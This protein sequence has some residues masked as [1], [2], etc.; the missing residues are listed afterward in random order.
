MRRKDLIGLK[1]A[2]W[3]TGMEA[4]AAARYLREVAPKQTFTYIDEKENAALPDQDQHPTDKLVTSEKD[5][6]QA[7]ET[8]DVVIKS[9]GVSLYHPLLQTARDRKV[10]IT[11]LLN[12]WSAENE[13]E[14][15]IAIT[16]TKGKSTTSS[17]LTHVLEQ[18]GKHV[19]LLG[20]F[21]VPVTECCTQDFD[22]VVV[23]FS[24]YQTATFDGRCG[25]GLLTALYPEHLDWHQ[26]LQTY[27]RDKSRLLQQ[28]DHALIGRQADDVMKAHALPCP[29]PAPDII[30]DEA[31]FHFV[32]DDLFK[33]SEKIGP[34]DNAYLLRAHNRLNVCGVMG[35][36]EG[37]SLPLD[38]ALASMKYYKGLPH[39]EQEIGEKDGIL[40]VDDSISTTPQSALAAL[41]AYQDKPVTLIAGGQDR[42][43]DFTPLTDYLTQT[44]SIPVVCLGQS[45]ATIATLLGQ[46]P[47]LHQAKTM[48]Q[49]VQIAQSVT[50]QGGVILLSP[51]SPSYDMFE[52]YMARAQAFAH[53]AGLSKASN[54][55]R[56]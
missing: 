38:Q 31:H 23:E 22:Y 25:I 46:R 6:R 1:I 41:A 13:T 5:I 53:E 10:P 42:G 54:K 7:L 20:N 33:G 12:L 17:L 30:D 36:I 40:Y 48:Q 52:N 14:K 18:M 55:I 32:G 11:S 3:G 26:T 4:T 16:G 45:G 24:S 50:P 47:N 2:I 43:I 49:A 8:A 44:P 35:I 28:C 21:G 34:L 19:T 29:N 37:L 39:R 51:A 9:P 27:Y 56:S 15:I